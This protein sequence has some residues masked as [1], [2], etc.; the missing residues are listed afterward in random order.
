MSTII[1][2]K[3]YEIDTTTYNCISVFVAAGYAVKKGEKALF[4]A[5]IWQKFKGTYY[6]HTAAFFGPAQVELIP[7]GGK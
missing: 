4:K 5:D 3:G 2:Y 6:K 7:E 1:I